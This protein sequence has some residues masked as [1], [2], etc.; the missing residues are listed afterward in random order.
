MFIHT[1]NPVLL[2]L[3]PVQ[4]RYYGLFY[5]FGFLMVYV[6]LKRKMR[7]GELKLSSEHLEEFFLYAIL[8]VIAGARLFYFISSEPQT[9]LSDPFEVLR[10]WH[11]GMSF[12]GG[13][14]GAAAAIYLFSR[15]RRISFYSI[16]DNV[17]IPASFALALGR[18]ANFINAELY[19]KIADVPWCVVFPGA[20]GCRHPSQLYDAA[21]HLI[22]AGMLMFIAK[23][24]PK[25]GIM[26]WSF[27]LIYGVFRVITNLFRDDPRMELMIGLS[28]GMA[29]VGAV[30]VYRIQKAGQ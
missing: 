20:D 19:G 11:G 22:M 16:A 2:Q 17:V 14:M 28:T 9:L 1:I 13:L 3:G 7:A 8:G 5:L 30:M 6:W 29:V 26:S 12:H 10:I 15:R 25:P 21:S 18:I 4:I 24:K 27:V 23:K